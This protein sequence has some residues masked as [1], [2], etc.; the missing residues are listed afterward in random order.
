MRLRRGFRGGG[1]PQ[2]RP[3]PT[4]FAMPD[5]RRLLTLRGLRLACGKVV[6]AQALTSSSAAAST[7]RSASLLS[8]AIVDR[9]DWAVMPIVLPIAPI[10]VQTWA[11]PPSWLIAR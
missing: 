11:A 1:L 6:M 4:D 3:S 2:K 7:G 10:D 9:T 5:L 8:R